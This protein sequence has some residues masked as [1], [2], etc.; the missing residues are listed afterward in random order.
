MG[1]EMCIRDSGG[2][3]RLLYMWS[4]RF[5]ARLHR[6]A[7]KATAASQTLQVWNVLR[8]PTLYFHAKSSHFS[9]VST[10]PPVVRASCTCSRRDFRPGST[11]RHVRQR[12]RAKPPGLERF[13][14]AYALGVHE[15]HF[16]HVRSHAGRATVCEAMSSRFSPSGSHVKPVFPVKK[17]CQAVFPRQ[18]AAPTMQ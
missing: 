10:V 7:R 5:S 3:A 13:T 16:E 1:S 8:P 15:P 18:E 11:A 17:P 4:A 6:P 12:P 9:V 14:S 2:I